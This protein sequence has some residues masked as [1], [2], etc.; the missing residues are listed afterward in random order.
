VTKSENWPR[1]RRAQEEQLQRGQPL[2]I[3][4][5]SFASAAQ[6]LAL[7]RQCLGFMGSDG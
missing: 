3:F 2:P 1:E 7:G 4:K 6:I 5:C